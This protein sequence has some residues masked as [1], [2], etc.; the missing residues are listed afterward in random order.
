M[1]R[2]A[3]LSVCTPLLACGRRRLLEMRGEDAQ[4]KGIQPGKP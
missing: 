2:I 1:R 4:G 3:D